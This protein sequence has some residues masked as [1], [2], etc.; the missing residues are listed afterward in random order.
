MLFKN[1]FV[2]R[3]T[4]PVHWS[5]NKLKEALAD[6]AFSPCSANDSYRLGWVAPAPMIDNEL[7]YT[8]GR[9]VLLTLNKEEKIL[10]ASVVN[11]EVAKRAHAIEE[12][13]QR[14]L[15]KK[16]KQELKEQV[17][18]VL[19]PKAFTRSKRTS[20]YLD[21]LNGLLI[22]DT[23]SPTKADE[24]TA[25]L[26]QSVGTLPI[27]FVTLKDSPTQHFSTWVKTDNCPAPLQLGDQC[28]LRAADGTDMIIRCKGTESL[29]EA[30]SSHIDAGMQVTQVALSWD[31]KIT[32][33]LSDEVII[34]RLKYLD[35]FQ[36]AAAENDSDAAEQFV[37]KFS[38]LTLEFEQM[39]NDI[40]AALGGEDISAII[41]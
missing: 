37:A 32:F 15:R 18:S 7:I 4:K 22:V 13:E 39:L 36:E 34:K 6:R 8:H 12:K 20:A 5:A 40:F 21:T 30:I 14:K 2:Y 3:F 38:L 17:I 35:R 19:L 16:E 28:D 33:L 41:S 11:D 24:F 10:P 25:T 27:G 31:E 23:P 26:R 9:Y 1:A 29:T